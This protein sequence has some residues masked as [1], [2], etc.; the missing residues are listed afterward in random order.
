MADNK[1]A[2]ILRWHHGDPPI[3]LELI[4]SEVEGN[5]R[6]RIL[7]VY[8]DAV[9]ANLQANMKLV[10]GVRGIIGGKSQR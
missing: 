4:L 6:Q 3:W 8:L 10:E 7:G 2:D 5:E 9:Q 1:L